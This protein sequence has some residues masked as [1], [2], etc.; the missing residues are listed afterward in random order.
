MIMG[1]PPFGPYAKVHE[2]N[3]LFVMRG[4]LNAW[5]N[6]QDWHIDDCPV[7]KAKLTNSHLVD[8]WDDSVW[9]GKNIKVEEF[10]CSCNNK[11]RIFD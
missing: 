1:T 11:I 9:P 7:C 2:Q 8:V 3:I 10:D 6:A 4:K 5:I